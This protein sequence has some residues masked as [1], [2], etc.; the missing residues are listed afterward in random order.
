MFETVRIVIDRLLDAS[1]RGLLFYK[2]GVKRRRIDQCHVTWMCVKGAL[3]MLQYRGENAGT[4]RIAE[5]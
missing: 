3:E 5:K 4:K 2:I 1:E